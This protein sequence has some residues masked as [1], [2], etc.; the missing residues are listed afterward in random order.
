MVSNP[1]VGASPANSCFVNKFFAKRF[2]ILYR[3]IKYVF[4]C[5]VIHTNTPQCIN[6]KPNVY[7]GSRGINT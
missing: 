6:Q 7:A 4:P 1:E 2:L 3:G 5:H